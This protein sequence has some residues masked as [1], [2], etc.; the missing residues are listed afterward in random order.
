[1][2]MI[3]STSCRKKD[4]DTTVGTSTNCSTLCAN[5]GPQSAAGC[6]PVRSWARRQACSGIAM[7][8]SLKGGTVHR[9]TARQDAPRVPL[10]PLLRP[11]PSENLEP[12]TAGLFHEKLR[13][14]RGGRPDRRHVVRLV[15]PPSPSPVPSV[16]WVDHRDG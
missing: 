3:C 9:R 4:G 16:L 6:C 7:S 10:Y 13:L 8:K 15:L 1:M 12:P 11:R 14:G 2:S 5:H